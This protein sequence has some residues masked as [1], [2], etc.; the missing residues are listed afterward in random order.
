MLL[1]V[2]S[3]GFE[4]G[5][6]NSHDILANICNVC[7]LECHKAQNLDIY[8]FLCIFMVYWCNFDLV[9]DQQNAQIRILTNLSLD[10]LS[11]VIF[12]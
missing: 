11:L 5:T 8:L 9:L 10:L 1:T 6:G 12:Y 4:V 7:V 3:L 2:K